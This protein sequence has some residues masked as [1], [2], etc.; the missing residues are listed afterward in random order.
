MALGGVVLQI[1]GRHC[2]EKSAL[3]DVNTMDGG[4]GVVLEFVDQKVMDLGGTESE[5]EYRRV[6][7]G[8]LGELH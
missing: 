3:E 1:D 4:N 6:V 7:Y 8:A 2:V 5:M